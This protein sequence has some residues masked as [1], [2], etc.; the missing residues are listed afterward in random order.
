MQ[1]H[2]EKLKETSQY[3]QF[4][5]GDNERS[6]LLKLNMVCNVWLYL[7]HVQVTTLSFIIWPYNSLHC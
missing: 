4:K 7:L 1:K 2:K 3:I 5:K 6:F